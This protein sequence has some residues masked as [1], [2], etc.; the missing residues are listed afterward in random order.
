M[1]ITD[2][3]LEEVK[4]EVGAD[5]VEVI[6]EMIEINDLIIV[7]RMNNMI[8]VIK[9]ND[10]P[11]VEVVEVEEVEVIEEM[12]EIS[13]AKILNHQEEVEETIKDKDVV[14]ALPEVDKMAIKMKLEEG[15]IEDHCKMKTHGNGNIETSKDQHLR[16]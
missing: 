7:K 9:M 14:K 16:K 2:L 11:L 3:Q 8:I 1:S 13:L 5:E 12:K 15:A 4:I 6:T 10:L